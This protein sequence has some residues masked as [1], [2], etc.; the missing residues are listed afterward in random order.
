MSD[1][2]SDSDNS[3][4]LSDLSSGDLHD[5][6]SDNIRP[7]VSGFKSKKFISI[8]DN[9]PKTPRTVI[10]EEIEDATKKIDVDE[11]IQDVY[12]C[13]QI[14]REMPLGGGIPFLEQFLMQKIENLGQTGR[15]CL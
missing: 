11:D 9:I 14:I 10:R 6:R 12:F 4:K 7:P 3:D 1:Q 5:I 13:T 8:I 2:E 15:H